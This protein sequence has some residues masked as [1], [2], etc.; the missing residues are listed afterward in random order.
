MTRLTATSAFI[1]PSHPRR[2][3]PSRDLC[4]GPKRRQDLFGGRSRHLQSA[5]A[6]IITHCCIYSESAA[7]IL[8]RVEEVADPPR[9]RAARRRERGDA[10]IA[11][12]SE[13]VSGHC[14][15]FSPP[16]CLVS[17]W[18]GIEFPAIA[19]SSPSLRCFL[20]A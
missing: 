16:L 2:L 17:D 20:L 19:R 7:N 18:T 15:N 12:Q 4:T 13:T 8:L 3:R 14:G 1:S 10:A 9:R 6:S 5:I 11:F